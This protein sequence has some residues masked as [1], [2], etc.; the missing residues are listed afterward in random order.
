MNGFLHIGNGETIESGAIGFRNGKID[1]IRNS[2]AYTPES[3]AWDTIIDLGGMH[4]YPGFFAPNSTLGLTELDAVRATRD[5]EEVGEFNPHIRSQ[6]AYNVESDVIK[7]VLT[8]GV[9]FTQA[10]PRGGRI[11][12]MSSIMTLHGWNWEDATI[13]VNDGLHINWPSY[14]SS[15]DDSKA[16]RKERLELIDFYKLAFSY[17]TNKTLEQKT[18]VRLDAMRSALNG[19]QRVFF[20]ANRAQEILDVI[21]FTEQFDIKYPVIVGGNESYQVLNRLK[22]A[23]IPVMLTRLHSLP[24]KDED[25]ID[26]PYKLPYLLQQAGVLYCLQNEGDMEAMHARNIPFL[27]GTAVAY[28]LTVEQAIASV[29]LNTAKILGLES[30]LGSLEIGKQASVF[31]SKGNALDP[32]SHQVTHI[33]LDGNQIP[34][35]NRQLELYNNYKNKYKTK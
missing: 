30:Q 9:L 19:D 35:S 13:Q 26:L 5:F 4:V 17:N 32:I 34:V 7:T 14:G 20:H 12:G 16:Y 25:P 10:T 27:A 21:A 22:D 2:L 33:F 18:D 15:A 11:S 31:V 1:L 6:I 29:S 23:N 28:G 24:V 8:N 3:Q